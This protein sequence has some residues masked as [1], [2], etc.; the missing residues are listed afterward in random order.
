MHRVR[1]KRRSGNPLCRTLSDIRAAPA[2]AGTPNLCRDGSATKGPI[3]LWQG[4]KQIRSYGAKPLDIR[5]YKHFA[6]TE[7]L[8]QASIKTARNLT[9]SPTTIPALEVIR[10]VGRA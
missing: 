2:K 4:A 9:D 3:L 10:S 5:F 1:G 6:P 7:L 8:Q